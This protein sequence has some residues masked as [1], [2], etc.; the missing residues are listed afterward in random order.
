MRFLI[1]DTYYPDF[2]RSVYTQHPRW[3][4]KSYDS[5]WQALMAECFGTAN[6][7]SANLQKLGHEATEVVA[8]CRPLQLAW[9]EENRLVLRHRFE[10]RKLWGIPVPWLARNWTYSILLAQVKSYR[11]DVVHFQDPIGTDP[12][13]VREIRASVRLV[14]AQIASP[15]PPGVDFRPYDL[16]LSSLP[17][18]VKH[19]SQLGLRSAYFKLAFEPFVLDRVK[20][21]A[22]HNAVF[23]GGL[24]RSHADRIQFLEQVSRRTS[25]QWWGYGEERLAQGSPLRRAYQGAAWAGA[26]YDK[27]FNARIALNHHIGISGDYANNM[28]LYEATGVGSLLLTDQKRN[29][30]E[31][32]EPG[33]E[34]V[35]YRSVGECV[36]LIE[37][38]LSHEED[39]AAIA[40]AGQQ[41]TFREHR[42]Y[43]R[44]Q[45]Y[46][47]L[48]SRH[49]C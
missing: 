49:V 32:F 14:T 46:L 25:I 7:Y 36:E 5:Q 3:D 9:A 24:S 37:H 38:Y 20:R 41:R 48:V 4:L 28:R 34:V 44:M 13:L 31:L 19:F 17:H 45:E 26:M 33:R 39:R 10:H 40:R 43:C 30:A 15:I 11:P 22:P 23:V 12:D 8:N 35:T 6:F 16:M 1:V 42:Y 29:L 2:L 47:E 21:T 18:F 27:L